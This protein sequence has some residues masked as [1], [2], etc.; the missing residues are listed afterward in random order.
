VILVVAL[1]TMTA[2]WAFERR[3]ARRGDRVAKPSALIAATV[4]AP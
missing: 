3:R 2:V 1:V 4:C